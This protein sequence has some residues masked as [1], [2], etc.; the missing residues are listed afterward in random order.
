M[1]LIDVNVLLYALRTDAPRHREHVEWLEALINGPAPFG[2]SAVALAAV[3]RIATNRRIY[4]EP[5]PLEAV[6]DFLADVR[7]APGFRLVTEGPRHWDVFDG[8]VRHARASGNLVT[9]AYFAALA[10]ESGCE[11]ITGDQDYALFP[12]LTYRSPLAD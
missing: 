8:L 3:V 7:N 5:A 1:I 10:I 2:I 9:D 6:L 4:R 11:L 12:G